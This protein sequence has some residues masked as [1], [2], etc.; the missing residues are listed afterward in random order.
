ML[1]LTDKIWTIAN[2]L[3]YGHF[4]INQEKYSLIDDHLPFINKG[5]PTTLII[6]F[7]YPYWHTNFRYS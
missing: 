5:I 4:F 1:Y 6:D 2:S 3:G 7:D